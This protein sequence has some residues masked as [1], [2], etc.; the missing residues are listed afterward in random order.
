MKP[1]YTYK[2]KDYTTFRELSETLGKDGI[3]IPWSISEDSLKDLGVT[4]TTE[5]ESLESI[6]EHK[7]LTLKIQRDNL[8][9]E[10]I[11]YQGYAFDYDSKARDRINAAII[12]LEVA[13]SSALLTWTT[14]DNKDVKV[15]ASDLRGVIAQVALRSDKLHTAYR[16]AKA[17]VEA[18][19][20]KEDIEAIELVVE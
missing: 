7:I 16:K 14:T 13:G 20:T 15:S 11:T 19:T 17:K 12:A 3:F 9:V 18:A 10:P 8:E 2:N 4:V 6:K 5:E 1:T